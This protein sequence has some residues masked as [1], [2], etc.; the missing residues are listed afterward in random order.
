M[1]VTITGSWK[2]SAQSEKDLLDVMMVLAL[3]Y[4]FD[5]NRKKR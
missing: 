4:R 5:M 1:A 3:S 2:S